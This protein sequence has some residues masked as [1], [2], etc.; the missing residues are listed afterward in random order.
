MRERTF[1][2]NLVL[3]QLKCS[4]VTS[5]LKLME[6]GYPSRVPFDDLYN[7]YDVFLPPELMKLNPKIFCETML[8]SLG[9][10][11]EDFKFGITRIFFRPNRFA[12]FDRILRS[13]PKDLNAIVDKVKKWLE[14]RSATIIQKIVRGFLARKKHQPRL[15]GIARFKAAAENAEEMNQLVKNFES[16]SDI[17]LKEF[18]F[19]EQTINDHIKRIKNNPGILPSE[20]DKL[21]TD[22]VEKYNRYNTLLQTALATVDPEISR[23]V[24]LGVET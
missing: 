6:C 1:D 20:I 18:S 12:E 4:G 5:L 16:C 19:L 22:M 8:H 3:T 23:F 24:Y 10:N 2:G 13:D 9:L 14:Y 17:V 15:R 21:Y 7:M 11:K